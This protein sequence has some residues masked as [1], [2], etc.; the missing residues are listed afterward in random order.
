M[1]IITTVAMKMF[2]YCLKF[3]LKKRKENS[4]RKVKIH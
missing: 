4:H 1:C 3:Y 2:H